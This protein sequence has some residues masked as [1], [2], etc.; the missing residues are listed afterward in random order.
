MNLPL[1]IKELRRASVWLLLFLVLALYLAFV[2][3]AAAN[4][5]VLAWKALL[6]T[7]AA[8]LGYW[9][10]RNLFPGAR[11][12]VF[13][14]AAKVAAESGAPDTWKA[15]R[16]TADRARLRRAIVVAAVVLAAALG[17]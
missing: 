2:S 4:L 3:R 11:P 12:H 9:V 10:D 8:W 6:L 17:V 1:V 15:Y 16:E 7:G 5:D 13:D 14:A